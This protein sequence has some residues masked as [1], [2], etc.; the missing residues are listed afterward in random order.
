LGY[1]ALQ[2]DALL[3]LMPPEAIDQVYTYYLK[4]FS[5]TAT[6]KPADRQLAYAK[7]L[8]TYPATK[9]QE[10]N[11]AVSPF[12]DPMY[13]YKWAIEQVKST[14]PDKV[15]AAMETL[16]NFPGMVGPLSLS[17]ENHCGIS[18]ENMA[19]CKIS[20]ARDPRAMGAF[21]ERIPG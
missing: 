1:A 6:E 7:K 20:S 9:G 16:K 19:W 8:L 5:Y 17:P 21:R 11:A 2:S 15:K 3:D 12:Y 18:Q 10:P 14:D 4:A 13:V